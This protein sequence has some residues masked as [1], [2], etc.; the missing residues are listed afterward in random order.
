V[1]MIEAHRDS[2]EVDEHVHLVVRDV[3]VHVVEV[4]PAA[5]DALQL[6]GAVLDSFGPHPLDDP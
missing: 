1:A 3:E 5:K 2:S 6:F 4:R